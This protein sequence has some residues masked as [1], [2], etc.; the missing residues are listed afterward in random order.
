MNLPNSFDSAAVFLIACTVKATVILGA[1][2][3]FTG[4]F[5]RRSAAFRHS[6]WAAAILGTL[7]LP[8]LMLIMP[9]WHSTTLGNAAAAFEPRHPT[10]VD[11]SGEAVPAMI[12]NALLASPVS[13]K[14]SLWVL[15]IW[16]LG[17]FAFLIRI[18]LG[19][20]GLR[21]LFRQSESLAQGDLQLAVS[22]ISEQLGIGR[23]L[24]LRQ[25][26]QW[27]AMPVTWG[28]LQPTILLPA[29]APDW[30]K[31]R[32]RSV[33]I[34]EMAHVARMDWL[35]QVFA[36]FLKAIYWFHPFS[37]IAATQLR[38]ES[39]RSCD[40]F[41]LNSGIQ[42]PEYAKQLIELASSLNSSSPSWSS[43]L[44]IA[45]HTNLE[46]R[47]TAMLQ[48][49]MDRRSLSRGMRIFLALI[50]VLVLTPLAA[51][52]LPAQNT[53]KFGGTISD[54]SGLPIA[55]A[56]IVLNNHGT[57]QIQM[58]TSNR[59][60]KYSFV[61]L[62]AGEYE[63]RVMK[64]GFAELRAKIMADGPRNDEAAEDFTL[65]VAPVNDEIDVVAHDGVKG[66]VSGGAIGGVVGGAKG[67]VN[68][69]VGGGVKANDSKKTIRIKIGGDVQA[70][71]I[72]E[73]V[74][75]VYPD[76]ART[77]GIEG[78]VILHA[79]IGMNGSPLSLKVMNNQ[80]DPDLAKAAVEAVSKWR[81]QPTLLNGDP[82][83][84]DTTIMVKFTLAK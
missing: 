25:A 58:T 33:L 43:A 1:A 55:N 2:L 59:A 15:L 27:T 50:T 77:A 78:T 3:L 4:A 53:I 72:V 81:Y 19:F 40:D 48:P 29:S 64:E 67:G 39:E 80:I 8:L 36:E 71:K 79:V 38:R 18:A 26:G 62:P 54:P 70:A 44:A 49:T 5:R 57:N 31:V 63:L 66:G 20:A 34:H 60:G 24:R 83:E 82:I 69:G 35:F 76:A 23:S 32:K 74:Q 73:K 37:W 16:G 6:I 30:S 47:F 9:T 41:V 51:V 46:R 14:R 10:I 7:A 65:L 21:R 11:A 12:I 17:S 75:P 52:R 42:A 13:G 56:T 61:D 22:E 84:V 68:D 45:R 28:A